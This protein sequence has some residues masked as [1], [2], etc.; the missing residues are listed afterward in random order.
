MPKIQKM[1]IPLRIPTAI[2]PFL[3]EMA[4]IIIFFQIHRLYHTQNIFILNWID[5]Q[6]DF[7]KIY[8]AGFRWFQWQAE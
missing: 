6:N 3:N 2:W 7:Q 5:P 4:I 1:R 8:D